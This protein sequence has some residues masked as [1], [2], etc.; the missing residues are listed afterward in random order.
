[1]RWPL[2]LLLILVFAGCPRP[3]PGLGDVPTA[4]DL[5]LDPEELEEALGLCPDDGP[6]LLLAQAHAE[7]TTVDPIVEGSTLGVFNAG[8]GGVATWLTLIGHEVPLSYP[9]VWVSISTG[10]TN[11]NLPGT[12]KVPFNDLGGD[13]V[14]RTQYMVQFLV[15]CCAEDFQQ[16]PAQLE[17]HVTWS[18]CEGLGSPCGDPCGVDSD[19]ATGY[20]CDEAMCRLD[21]LTVDIPIFLNEAPWP[22]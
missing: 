7:D 1:M 6:C 4:Q 5:S 3:N 9:T 22:L 11:H 12:L 20:L 14:A 8:Q 2:L 10:P 17:A 21:T 19:C 13:S 18:D 15:G 16:L